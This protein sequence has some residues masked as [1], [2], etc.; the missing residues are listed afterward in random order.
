MGG[1]WG[2]MNRNQQIASIIASKGPKMNMTAPQLNPLKGI[3]SL[4][5]KPLTAAIQQKK[6]KNAI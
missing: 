3:A 1:L 2:K 4:G 6:A 5:V